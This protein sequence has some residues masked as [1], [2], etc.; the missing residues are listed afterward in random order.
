MTDEELLDAALSPFNTAEQERIIRAALDKLTAS[1]RAPPVPEPA[2]P[3]VRASERDAFEAWWKLD[4][5]Y[6]SQP[7]ENCF[8]AWQ[9]RAALA[10]PEP[11]ERDAVLREARETLRNL[12]LGA[13]T[14]DG[15]YTRNPGNFAVALRDLREYAAAARAAL[16]RIDAALQQEAGAAKPD[17]RDAVLPADFERWV[18]GYPDALI[19]RIAAVLQRR[20]SK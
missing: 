10:H 4:G 13:N 14:V 1:R 9:A 19:A 2:T 20:M 5:R 6:R 18:D 3:E 8:H 11:D 16:A 12:E 7:K 15:C 17:E